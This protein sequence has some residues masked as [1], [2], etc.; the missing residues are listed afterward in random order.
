MIWPNGAHMQVD[1]SSYN[2][3][4]RALVGAAAVLLLLSMPLAVAQ[5]ARPGDSL[6]PVLAAFDVPD[7]SLYVASADRLPAGGSGSVSD[8]AGD[9]EHPTG[10][11]P[12]FTSGHFDILRT[13][14]FEFDAGPLEEHFLGPTET[15]DMWSP[16]GPREL[17]IDDSESVL[18]ITGETPSDGSEFTGG[19]ILLG[20]TLAETPETPVPG[21]CEYVVWM[22]DTS[23]GPTFVNHPAFP[24]D[25]AV[26][27]NVAYGVRLEPEQRGP[28]STFALV[29]EEEAGFEAV[30][31]S[32]VRAFVG[33][34]YV[35]LLV[36]RTL[37]TFVTEVNFHSFCS[38][39]D[40]TF[41]PA[42]SGGDQTGLVALTADSIGSMTVRLETEPPP[43]TV[44]VEADASAPAEVSPETA[45]PAPV[46]EGGPSPWWLVLIAL[47]GIAS[48]GWF[49]RGRFGPCAEARA[50]HRQATRE[51][52]AL[53]RTT[54]R[55][56]ADAE[57]LDR[58]LSQLESARAELCRAWPPLCWETEDGGWIENSDGTRF[59]ARD[60]HMRKVALGS[61]W[62][63]YKSGL[64]TA[65]E[66]EELWSS[67]DTIKLHEQLTEEE[68][69]MRDRLDAIDRNI[70][71]VANEFEEAFARAQQLQLQADKVCQRAETA[72]AELDDCVS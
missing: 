58:R 65:A 48:A 67:L 2:R 60:V 36:P 15:S 7:G 56:L 6:D 44:R 14:I 8:P 39:E 45:Q 41:E 64:I 53:E 50:A 3:K 49:V 61:R 27:T 19:A 51:C 30:V 38:E 42:T 43:T 13:W 59:T 12:E 72:K 29:H 52:K 69:A 9:F 54:D 26:G 23:K 37:M 5:S 46:S 33:Q 40:L 1:F 11:S 21:R 70:R 71:Q 4:A 68:R 17:E 34:S 31:D 32:R 24:A 55:A 62:D 20:F 25:P 57:A 35:G 10:E 22:N 47:V 28:S 63:D 16:S 18:T 66:V